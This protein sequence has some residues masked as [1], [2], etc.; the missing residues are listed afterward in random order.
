MVAHLATENILT[1]RVKDPVS[2]Y[3]WPLTLLARGRREEAGNLLAC[4]KDQ[5][6]TES[7]DL[8]SDR[9]GF[10][11]EFHHYANLWLVL[12]AIHLGETRLTEKLL[13]FLLKHHNEKTGG[14]ASNRAGSMEDPLTTSFL[15]LALCALREEDLAN[16]VLAY[17][18]SCVDRQQEPDCFRL[19]TMLPP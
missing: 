1:S 4:I 12:A 9:V 19:R 11:L 2:Y 14:L 13:G 18:Q 6:L 5:C 7:G 3:K 10:H 8:H 17:L 16:R 15:G